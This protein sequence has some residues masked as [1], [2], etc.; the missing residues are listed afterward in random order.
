M[1]YRIITRIS[2]KS[3]LRIFFIIVGS[4]SKD[5]GILNDGG[6]FLTLK[7]NVIS[8]PF[9]QQARATLFFFGFCVYKQ[10]K[11]TKKIEIRK[12][13]MLCKSKRMRRLTVVQPPQA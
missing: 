12:R 3:F 13:E 9:L 7:A 6:K 10:K 8:Y 5:L 1:G 11:R 2:F 4:I